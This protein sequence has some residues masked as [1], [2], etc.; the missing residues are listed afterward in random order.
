MAPTNIYTYLQPLS[1]HEA[2]PI[3][4]CSTVARYFPSRGIGEQENR[5][6]RRSESDEADGEGNCPQTRGENQNVCRYDLDRAET[7]G[8]DGFSSDGKKYPSCS[9]QEIGRAHVCTPVTHAHI[10]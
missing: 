5:E 2:L 10:V 4:P 1:R 3:I 8:R 7:G 9:P 6:C